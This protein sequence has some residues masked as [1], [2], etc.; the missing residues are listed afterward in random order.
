MMIKGKPLKIILAIERS[1]P[2]GTEKQV[3]V[4][5]KKLKQK[6]HTVSV[7]MTNYS[8]HSLEDEHRHYSKELSNMGV[9]VRYAKGITDSDL[10]GLSPQAQSLE[11]F[12]IH[13]DYMPPLYRKHVSEF[14][15]EFLQE[16]LN[17][18]PYP[19]YIG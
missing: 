8:H 16:K 3:T 6:G 13:L 12:K 14:V 15:T 9:P 11:P 18:V 1:G 5:A 19:I 17:K 7:L 4:L 10:T 2:G